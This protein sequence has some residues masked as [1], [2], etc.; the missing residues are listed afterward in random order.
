M[1]RSRDLSSVQN[2]GTSAVSP[3]VAGKNKC[4]NGGFDFFQRGTSSS[5][6]QVYGADRWWQ[7]AVGSTTI[8]QS[9][10]V[11]SGANVRYS[12]QGLTSA[13]SSFP[14]F[15]HPLEQAEVIPLR[16][17]TMCVSW[18]MKV[19]SIW[20]DIFGPTIYYSNT[21]DARA[22]VTTTISTISTS[23]A[24]LVP[25]T[26]WARY[27]AVFAVPSDAVGLLF[28]FNPNVVQSSGAQINMT[29]V[30]IELG[31]RP[32]PFSRAQLDQQ[33]FHKARM[34]QAVQMFVIQ[35]KV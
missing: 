10:D 33:L 29:G 19:N 21:T 26:S 9:T 22:S 4:V 5:A 35:F 30:Q 6:D 17:Q 8:S 1:T 31:S 7:R 34:F 24:G 27:Y 23:P 32:T 14:Q 28:Q 18:Y 15:H 3:M 16:G 12:I 25:T 2:N 20:S 13:G 11:P